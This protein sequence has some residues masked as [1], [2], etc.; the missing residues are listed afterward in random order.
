M[1]RNDKKCGVSFNS[2]MDNLEKMFVVEEK[3]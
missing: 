1:I 3:Y 2:D